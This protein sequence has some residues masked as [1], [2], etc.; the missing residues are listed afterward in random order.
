[1]TNANAK[2]SGPEALSEGPAD[3]DTHDVTRLRR[4]LF[5]QHG[6]NIPS[7]DP[8]CTE[9]TMFTQ[10]VD[11]L[12]LTAQAQRDEELDELRDI[13]QGVGSSVATAIEDASK[14]ISKAMTQVLDPQSIADRVCSELF[15]DLQRTTR[16]VSREAR[17]T[18]IIAGL[19][20]TLG[21]FLMLLMTLQ[22][23]T[24]AYNTQADLVRL[25]AFCGATREQATSESHGND[26]APQ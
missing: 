12:L 19:A 20:T 15:D 23:L 24:S 13:V 7:T 3:D 25:G 18:I 17:W 21:C 5:K 16:Q 9:Y 11:E 2:T 26:R 14:P 4:E 22:G 8:I 10:V 1:M 6:I